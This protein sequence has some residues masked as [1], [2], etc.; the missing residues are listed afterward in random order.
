MRFRDGKR[1][2]MKSDLRVCVV[3][4]D[5]ATQ[6]ATEFARRIDAPMEEIHP[7]SANI[8]VD[9]VGI[10]E[11][12]RRMGTARFVDFAATVSAIGMPHKSLAIVITDPKKYGRP[13]LVTI[14][15]NLTCS[16]HG[17]PSGPNQKQSSKEESKNG[18]ESR[19]AASFEDALASDMPISTKEV[20][21]AVT[22]ASPDI[23]IDI[24]MRSTGAALARIGHF[25]RLCVYAD[26]ELS[27]GDEGRLC[28]APA[29]AEGFGVVAETRLMSGPDGG[30]GEDVRIIETI[31]DGMA[32][33]E[34][35]G[36][37]VYGMSR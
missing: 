25:A 28:M 27:V 3:F 11:R 20:A 7:T 5:P 13:P 36:S 24:A 17:C 33:S 26:E 29:L 22:K 14:A 34:I 15:R 12:Q 23:I 2:E 30:P 19:Q 31:R 18:G 4:D 37:V 35:I 21:N 10:A 16:P 9:Y 1:Y 6:F 32:I 8:P